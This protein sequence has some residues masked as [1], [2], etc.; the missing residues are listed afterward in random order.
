MH[1]TIKP[2]STSTFKL[3]IEIQYSTNILTAE[4]IVQPCLNDE[5]IL[6][7]KEIM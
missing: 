5:G 7:A 1:A 3:E 6:A 2:R 4:E